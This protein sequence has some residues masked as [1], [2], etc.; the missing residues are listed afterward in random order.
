[1]LGVH[2]LVDGPG[3]TEQQKTQLFERGVRADNYQQGHGIG[4]AIVKDLLQ[5]YQG[6]WQID[7]SPL[8]GAR[9]TLFLPRS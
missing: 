5:S 6:Q 2:I 8:G 7:Q 9:F 1:M 3:I 4:L